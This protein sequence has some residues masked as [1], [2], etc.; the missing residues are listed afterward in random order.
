MTEVFQFLVI[1]LGLDPAY[2]LDEMQLYEL[3]PLFDK[4]HLKERDSWEQARLIAWMVAQT[5][6]KKKIK[7]EDIAE[8]PWDNERLEADTGMSKKE[9][10]R[11]KA[12]AEAY[13]KEHFS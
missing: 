13:A 2:V 7:M 6:S 9:F 3:G 1:R 8:F 4:M 10:E 5:R 12:K 11:L